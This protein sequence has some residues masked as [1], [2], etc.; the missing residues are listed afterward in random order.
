MRFLSVRF[1][2]HSQ[3]PVFQFPYFISDF[4]S[5]FQHSLK[6][7]GKASIYDVILNRGTVFV[8]TTY[9]TLR[10]AGLH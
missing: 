6:F 3:Y 10:F 9:D 2:L 1:L 5:A 7:V 8:G 4:L